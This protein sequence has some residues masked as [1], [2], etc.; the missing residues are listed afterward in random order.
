MSFQDLHKS[1]GNRSSLPPS[2]AV[3]AALFQI[4][5]AVATFRRLVDAI[6]TS[7]DTPDHRLKLQNT[8]QR[9]LDLVKGTSAKLKSLTESDGDADP[10]RRIQNA[11]LARDF[12]TTLQEFQKVQQ[13]A[14]ERESM[15][16][17]AVPP[18]S[19][20]PS[21]SGPYAE[22]DSERENE[23]FLKEGKRQEVI[24]LD[25]DVAFNEAVIEEREQ[26]IEEIQYQITEASEIFKDL[27]VLIH[28][29]GGDIEDIQYKIDAS[30]AATTQSKGQLSKGSKSG[31]STASWCWWIIAII[32]AVVVI[33]LI[34]ILL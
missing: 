26:G 24:L 23:S 10:T 20:L 32:V 17:P 6:G 11:K 1:G 5:T 8:R 12:Q 9:I 3:A 30:A 7:K 31:K 15:F 13:F 28:D 21:S 25:N 29:Q 14:S 19:S 34:V 4:N 27:A 22:P 18:A 16:S 2:Q 33:L